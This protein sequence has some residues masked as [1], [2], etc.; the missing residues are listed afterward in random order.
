M[1][2]NKN[3][4]FLLIGSN[5][6]S[7]IDLKK[8][9][10]VYGIIFE[11]HTISTICSTEKIFLFADAFSHIYSIK[12]EDFPPLSLTATTQFREEFLDKH[13]KKSCHIGHKGMVVKI[14]H[15]KDYL[16]SL[17]DDKTVKVWSYPDMVLLDELTGHLN[18]ICSIAFAGQHIYTGSYDHTIRSWDY[19]EMIERISERKI[20]MGE[21]FYSMRGEKYK[22][23]LENKKK[24]KKK[25]MK[26]GMKK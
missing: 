6:V 19:N 25:G 4:L 16:F 1:V 8:S 18:G 12:T 7:I 10:I 22:G 11:D 3:F 13:P 26:K 17:S 9:T 23:F 15:F 5:E 21:H 2:L 20:M 24:K 14:E